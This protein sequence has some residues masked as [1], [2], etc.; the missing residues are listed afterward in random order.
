MTD[1]FAAHFALPISIRNVLMW[2]NFLWRRRPAGG[3]YPD[4]QIKKASRKKTG[5][6]ETV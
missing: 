4:P 2:R 5:R 6:P 3:F 1:V